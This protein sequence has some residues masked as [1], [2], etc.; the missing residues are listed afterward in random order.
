[1]S[2][3][4]GAVDTKHTDTETPP[5]IDG[6]PVVGSSISIIRDALEFAETAREHGDVVAYEAFG[7]DMVAV[8]DPGI[9]EQVLVSRNNGFR[10]GELDRK[11]GALIAPEGVVFTEGEQ[12]RR[13]RT[14]LQSWFTPARTRDRPR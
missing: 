3:T 5:R 9:V 10:K 6:L 13:Q 14:V 2:D 4:P 7:T 8:F 12:W 1:M 11:F